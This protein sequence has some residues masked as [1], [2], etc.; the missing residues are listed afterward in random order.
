MQQPLVQRLLAL[1][2]FRC[3]H[4]AFD[5][6]FELNYS[7]DDQLLLAWRHGEHYCRLHL[8]LSSLQAIIDYTDEQLKVSRMTC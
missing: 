2:R 3:Q 8:D 5:G 6:R 1:M 4:P 7:A